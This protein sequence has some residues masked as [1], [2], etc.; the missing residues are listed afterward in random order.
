M[1]CICPAL[2]PAQ[3]V[4]FATWL[5]SSLRRIVEHLAFQ[6]PR[7]L[8]SP[9]SAS[10]QQARYQ[11]GVSKTNS[12]EH[13]HDA[14]LRVVSPGPGKIPLYA[15]LTNVSAGTCLLTASTGCGWIS[16]SLSSRPGASTTSGCLLGKWTACLLSF[17][18][19]VV[20]KTVSP[21][22]TLK[23]DILCSRNRCKGS[24]NQGNG[25]DIYDL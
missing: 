17:D 22:S 5:S 2:L 4:L 9:A 14:G 12:G 7:F 19:E 11:D 13:D 10:E 23:T 15:M 25:Y 8:S 20:P 1:P 16:G 6:R 18:A 21:V 3:Y 24:S